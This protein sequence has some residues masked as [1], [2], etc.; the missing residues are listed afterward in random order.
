MKESILQ[1]A[2]VNSGLS[3]ALLLNIGGK[4]VNRSDQCP[5]DET[6]VSAEDPAVGS[7]GLVNLNQGRPVEGR[8]VKESLDL[9]EGLN[10]RLDDNLLINKLKK[11][12]EK[13]DRT[14]IA[15]TFDNITDR[16]ER[17]FG[18]KNHIEPAF[19]KDNLQ[20]EG[21]PNEIFKVQTT[22]R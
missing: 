6:P 10:F 22:P 5:V 15:E 11:F 20:G 13:I 16:E 14:L 21:L 2:S 9:K 8:I 4:P 17:K 12:A 7:P 19:G 18:S 1:G 3:G